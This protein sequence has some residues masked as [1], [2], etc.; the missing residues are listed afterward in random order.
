VQKTLRS[1]N[2][3]PAQWRGES[4][5]FPGNKRSR[6]IYEISQNVFHREGKFENMA[7]E[8]VL[9]QGRKKEIHKMFEHFGYFVEKLC[10]TRIGSL[11]LHGLSTGTRRRLSQADI[12]PLFK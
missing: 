8:V 1:H 6:R 5:I 10:H 4:E 12:L 9:S 2:F 3:A 7:F 11:R